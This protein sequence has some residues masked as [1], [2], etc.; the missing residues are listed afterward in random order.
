MHHYTLNGISAAGTMLYAEDV[1]IALARLEHP[2]MQM[3]AGAC[4]VEAHR[5]RQAFDPERMSGF[6]AG[7]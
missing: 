5:T 4:T 2:A 7:G 6:C 1:V 3:N